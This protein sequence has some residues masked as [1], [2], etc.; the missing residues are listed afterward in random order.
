MVLNLYLLP[1]ATCVWLCRTATGHIFGEDCL[2]RHMASV[3][4]PLCPTCRGGIVSIVRV[5]T[6]K[7]LIREEVK[8]RCPSEG[9][10]VV[11]ALND[12]PSHLSHDCPHAL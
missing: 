10:E 1:S 9:C 6:M 5:P 4:Q 7:A 2:Q 8:A 3:P 12:L 11:A